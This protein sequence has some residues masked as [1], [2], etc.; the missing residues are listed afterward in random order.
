MVW[1]SL[2]DTYA[3][4]MYAYVTPSCFASDVVNKT[5]L[6]AGAEFPTLRR[7]YK[8]GLMVRISY[9]IEAIPPKGGAT[10]EW[11][12]WDNTC[13]RERPKSVETGGLQA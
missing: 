11:F 10:S 9:R 4:V 13:E 12:K 5:G 6:G 8:T 2:C 7:G 1:A 3:L